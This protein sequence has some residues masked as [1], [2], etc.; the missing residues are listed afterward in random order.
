MVIKDL[1]NKYDWIEV[2]NSVGSLIEGGYQMDDFTETTLDSKFDTLEVI[3][4]DADY[5][6]IRVKL[7]EKEWEKIYN[8]NSD[9]TLLIDGFKGWLSVKNAEYNFSEKQI[10]EVIKYAEKMF[11]SST[12]NDLEKEFDEFFTKYIGL[13]PEN[14]TDFSYF[15]NLFERVEKEKNTY[16]TLYKLAKMDKNGFFIDIISCVAW[17]FDLYFP[18]ILDNI[19]A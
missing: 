15:S 1:I 19:A 8:P 7:K 2:R 9:Q 6:E 5:K 4:Y 18:N 13:R 16:P 14:A 17:I 3:E 12:D 10:R 11:G